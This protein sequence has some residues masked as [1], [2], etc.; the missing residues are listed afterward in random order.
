MRLSRMATVGILLG[1]ALISAG[2]GNDR[3][4]TAERRGRP[5][6]ATKSRPGPD[7]PCN[8][9][10]GGFLA[11]MNGLRRRLTVG[12]DYEH[13][14]GGVQEAQGAYERVPIRRLSIGCLAS[15]GTPAERALNR[16]LEAANEWGNCLARAGCDLRE[17]EP[18]LQR[19]WALASGLLSEALQGLRSAG[20]G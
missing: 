14:L 15:A 8:A 18:K 19:K 7:A 4:A 10:L 1:L 20:R 12:L 3:S 6:E 11:S 16:Y 5:Q 9:R 13:Y 2:C 17:V